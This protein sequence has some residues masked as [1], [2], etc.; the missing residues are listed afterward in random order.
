[1][2]LCA[3]EAADQPVY[4]RSDAGWVRFFSHGAEYAR[5]VVPGANAQLQDATHMRGRITFR[6]AETFTL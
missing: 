6:R 3:Q 5:F 1:M 2:Q 4:V